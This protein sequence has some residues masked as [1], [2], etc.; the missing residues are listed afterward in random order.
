MCS[1]M[2]P[3]KSKDGDE[4]VGLDAINDKYR[5]RT[6]MVYCRGLKPVSCGNIVSFVKDGYG[7][8]YIDPHQGIGKTPER[9]ISLDRGMPIIL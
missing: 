6:Y 5:I 1:K 8:Y 4:V 3:I 2:I 9:Y 7:K